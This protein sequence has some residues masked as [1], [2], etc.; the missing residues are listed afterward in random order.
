MGLAERKER[1]KTELRNL[2]LE[3]AKDV[4]LRDGQEGLSI[5]KIAAEIEYSPAT[6]Y[7]YFQDKDE[8]IHHLMEKGFELLTN[9]MKDIFQETDA[10]RRAMLIG[11]KYVEFG[12]ENKDWYS[13]MFNSE[14]P[15]NHIQR[16]K[17]EWCEGI[18]F[19][20]F[21]VATC[22]E[23]LEA[24]G[25]G[26]LDARIVALQ[27]WSLSHGLVNLSHARRLEVVD[28]IPDLELIEKTLEAA[29]LIYFNYKF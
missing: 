23:A 18:S 8:L 2:I 26:A 3:K 19:F 6:I 4:F 10:R 9:E 27:L 14:A 28:T 7:L 16:C 1:E 22:K 21:F 15:M 12:F 29:G 13:I 5:R 25:K 20:D 24:S 11:S 17:E